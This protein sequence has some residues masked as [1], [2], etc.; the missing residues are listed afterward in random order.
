[1]AQPTL[2]GKE[3]KYVMDCLDS[4]WI[5][6]AGK[7]VTAFEEA[8][9]KF[10]GVRYALTC[11]NGTVSLQLALAALGIGPGDEVIVPTFTYIASAN[12]VRYLGATPVFAECKYDT[13]NIDT[14]NIEQL[15]TPRTKAIMPV[16]LYGLMCDMDALNELAKKHN[17][18]I[19]EDAA[20]AHGAIYKG[21]KAGSFGII[22][23]FSFFGNKIITTGEGGMVTTDD[24]ALYNRMKLLRGQ[25]MDPVRRYWFTVT[26][27][28]FRMTNIQAAIGLAQLENI[29]SFMHK[30]LELARMYKQFL[31][32]E[33]FETQVTSPEYEHVYWMYSI[34]LPKDSPVSRDETIEKL[35]SEGI[36]TRPLFYPLHVMPPYQSNKSF[37]VSEEVANRGLNLPTHCAMSEQ[38]VQRVAEAIQ[39]ILHR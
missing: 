10:C 7:Y 4:N 27:Y 17:L 35:A 21:R 26:G 5:S 8:F 9:A 24:E 30:R 38:D 28:N 11:A 31:P 13:W 22:N 14:K 34:L 39:H 6:S 29:G 16:H 23:S 32:V 3:K 25:G 33:R 37:P 20:E 1:V 36:E 18:F 19:V 15:I 2:N 12:A